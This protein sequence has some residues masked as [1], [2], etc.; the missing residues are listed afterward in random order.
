MLPT[1][2]EG[3]STTP[4]AGLMALFAGFTALLFNRRKSGKKQ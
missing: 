2:G 4:V 3:T 1:T